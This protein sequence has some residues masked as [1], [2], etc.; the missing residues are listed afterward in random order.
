MLSIR[1]IIDDDVKISIPKKIVIKDTI[2]ELRQ[3]AKDEGLTGYSYM[4]K[5]DLVLF[6]EKRTNM[7][8]ERINIENFMDKSGIEK[9]IQE[10]FFQSIDDRKFLHLMAPKT[11]ECMDE[12]PE[13]PNVKHFLECEMKN[14]FFLDT[15]CNGPY[16]CIKD[17]YIYIYSI[18]HHI[19]VSCPQEIEVTKLNI[20]KKNLNRFNGYMNLQNI[21]SFYDSAMM[22]CFKMWQ[23]VVSLG[24]VEKQNEDMKMKEEVSQ[25]LEFP[26]SKKFVTRDRYALNYA[27]RKN[28]SKI[29]FNRQRCWWESA[30]TRFDEETL[31]SMLSE[32]INQQM[33]NLSF[34]DHEG[35]EIKINDFAKLSFYCGSSDVYYNK[36]SGLSQKL[37]NILS[38]IKP[39]FKSELHK[40]LNNF[41]L[42]V[43]FD[44]LNQPRRN[45]LD[46]FCEY[47]GE[48]EVLELPK[49][50]KNKKNEYEEKWRD[51]Y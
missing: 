23:L 21:F 19:T 49:L 48:I 44:C 29:C 47:D 51:Y 22:I 35:K 38:E 18:Y 10:V 17:I 5:E 46:I 37:I 27:A 28:I 30:C 24:E 2:K 9:G 34:L 45:I 14:T 39:D 8:F 4:S 1:Y 25:L 50:I 15:I 42:S 26:N 20:I 40:I 12:I 41:M 11:F 3:I 7:R 33:G 43:Q 13:F 31:T 36:R 32:A 16:Q 6:L